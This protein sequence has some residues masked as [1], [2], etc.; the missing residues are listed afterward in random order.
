MDTKIIQ[1]TACAAGQMERVYGLG[2]DQKIYFWSSIKGE[3]VLDVE[4]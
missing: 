2:A 3:W 1:I 4:E